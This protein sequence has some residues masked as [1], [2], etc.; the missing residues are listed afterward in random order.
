VDDEVLVAF[1]RGDIDYP[2][3]LGGLYGHLENKPSPHDTDLVTDRHLNRL[4]LVS[5]AGHRLELLDA[6][7]KVP[8]HGVRLQ[9]GDKAL[10]V[11][12]DEIKT[13]ILIDSTGKVSITGKDKV[14][15][16]STGAVSVDAPSVSIKA[17]KITIEGDVTVT[18]A[19]NINGL[20]TNR[21]D[22]S[23]IGGLNSLGDA[24]FTG[25]VDVIGIL[26]EDGVPVV[27]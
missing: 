9:S 10:T 26:K 3:V 12:L 18:G 15:I 16:T 11:F 20:L 22:V 6:N 1:D 2:Y 24:V 23:I 19:M 25:D 21:G 13:E 17:P 7:G 8:K 27:P 5:R 4:S 14:S